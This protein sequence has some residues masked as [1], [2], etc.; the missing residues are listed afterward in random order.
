MQDNV[1]APLA[2][3]E[4]KVAGTKQRLGGMLAG[5]A[6]IAWALISALSAEA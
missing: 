4:R 2:S 5:V 1:R 3:N 6:V